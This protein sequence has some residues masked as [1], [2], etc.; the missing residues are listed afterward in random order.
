MYL[1]TNKAFATTIKIEKNKKYKKTLDRKTY[2][3]NIV[4]D[5][6]GV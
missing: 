1:H 5:T 4:H 2:F 6:I 3:E